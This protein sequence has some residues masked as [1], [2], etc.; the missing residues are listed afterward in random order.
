MDEKLNKK[1][2]TI[3]K[4]KKVGFGF[5][6]LVIFFFLAIG[7]G[8]SGYHYYKKQEAHLREA[9]NNQLDAVADL[10]VKEIAYWRDRRLEDA[11]I[12]MKQ[13][14]FIPYVQQ[15]LKYPN[16]S[17]LKEKVSVFLNIFR[18]N[19]NYKT[20]ILTDAQGNTRLSLPQE[21]QPAQHMYATT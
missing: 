1:E 14:S 11:T 21:R 4:K 10:K 12:I 15:W 16:D 5:Q 19:K 7:I 20:I 3:T 2:S 13:S 9:T 6:L 17:E 8:T 18:E